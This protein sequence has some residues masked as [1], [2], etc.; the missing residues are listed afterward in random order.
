MI[1]DFVAEGEV[2]FFHEF[3]DL[4][5]RIAYRREF[6]AFSQ[7]RT[8]FISWRELYPDLA[9]LPAQRPR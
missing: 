5:D 1:P 4:V 7:E 6:G 3:F 9:S 8:I 2:P